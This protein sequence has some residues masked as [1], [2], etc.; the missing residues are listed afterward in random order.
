MTSNLADIYND[1][2]TC[3][4]AQDWENLGL[5]CTRKWFTTRD[6]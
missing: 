5:L 3:L 4:N 1:Y 6:D 2:I